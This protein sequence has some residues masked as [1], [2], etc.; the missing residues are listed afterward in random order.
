M[1]DRTYFHSVYFR[2]PNGILFEMATDR[3]CLSHEVRTIVGQGLLRHPTGMDGRR[4][5]QV[6]VVHDGWESL[7]QVKA[8]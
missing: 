1:I 5:A 4:R 6:A 8:T 2:E 3:G 7:I